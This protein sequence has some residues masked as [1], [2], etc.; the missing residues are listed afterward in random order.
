MNKFLLSSSALAA[1][2][3]VPGVAHAQSTGSIEFDD[4]DA[5]II[6][7]TAATDAEGVE[8]PDDPKAKQVLGEE[9]IRRQRPGQTVN[10]IVNLVPGV[11]FQNNDPWGSSGGGFTIRG[12]TSDRISQTLDGLPLNDSGNYALY[13]N[14]QVDPEVLE[15][16]NVN[17]GVTDV[18]SPTASAVGGTI[19]IRTRL[20]ARDPGV[21]S[22]LTYG[23]VAAEGNS[24]DSPYYRAFGMVDFGDLTGSGTTAFFSASY[25]NYD[26]P[27][28]SYGQVDKQQY[29][30]R[31]F[32]ELDN[33]NFI[34]LS[35]HYNENRNNFAGSVNYQE[36]LDAFAAGDGAARF[37]LDED[38]LNFPCTV[39]SVPG[40]PGVADGVN[41]CGAEFSRRY[42]PSNTGNLRVSS[43]V[44]LTDRLTLT[45]DPSYQYVKANGGGNEELIEGVC[46]LGVGNRCNGNPATAPQLTGFIRGGYYYGRDLNGDG[47]TLDQLSGFDP[48]QTRTHRVG[49][50]SNLIY[51]LSDDHRVRVAYT[52]DHANHRQTGQTSI[53]EI[54]GEIPDV[55]PVNDPVRTR[56]GFELNK[57]DRQSYAILNQVSAEYRGQY[58]DDDL[59]TVVGLRAPFFVR[60][61]DQNC[62]TT[63]ASGFIDCIGDPR[64]VE[65]YRANNPN[66]S[67]PQERRYT[68]N[69]LLPNVGFTYAF[70]DASVFGNYARGLSVPGTDTLYDSFFFPDTD[71][72][73]PD[74]ETTDS[75]DAGVRYQN[76]QWQAQIAGYF[77]KYNNRLAVSY[78]PLLD[79]SITRNLG[80]VDK[81][82]FDAS[83]AYSPAPATLFY[84]FGGVNESEIKED[85]IDDVDANGNPILIPTAG[86]SESGAPLWM[87]GGRVQQAFG[88]LELGVQAKYTGKRFANDINTEEVPGY[89]LVDADVRFDLGEIGANNT[90]A[91]QFNVTN[92]FDEAYIGYVSP[93][94]DA[95]PSF[96]QIGAPRALS[97][98]F[99]LGY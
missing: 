28:N 33:G 74:P 40:T 91:L 63:S 73:R 77:T 27:Y 5:I 79:E 69:E 26:V 53:A 97:L 52:L 50:I 61:L 99:I 64:L 11:S 94:F 6:T 98:S 47:D 36:L 65:I 60:D 86:K 20:P 31:V 48:S 30:G 92:V 23:N 21:V 88:P 9:I 51:D 12:F 4:D 29:N 95:E 85:V 81:Y 93:S 10:D 34:S 66:V 14:Q 2:A 32:Q 3:L 13:T 43:L 54:D 15:E 42:N 39:D 46:F 49:V 62:F 70:G 76:R 8:I 59:T 75:F 67:A 22:T 17:L 56:D 35:G 16:V 90:A 7:G 84:V 80:P 83:I 37:R 87:V 25:L 19:N 82:G 24:F 1:C 78:D 38:D 57:R 18:D 71:D 44:N 55:F 58:L 72:A 41:G 89:M 45:I 68:Y 96:I